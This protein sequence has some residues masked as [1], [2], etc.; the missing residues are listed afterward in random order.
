MRALASADCNC[1]FDIC[2]TNFEPQ[3]W[4]YN[5]M[6]NT[7]TLHN[8]NT[9]GTVLDTVT[10][11]TGL[12]GLGIGKTGGTG[13][14]GSTTGQAIGIATQ[15]VQ[16]L[17]VPT[18]VRNSVTQSTINPVLI[19]LQNP[20]LG[21]WQ[22]GKPKPR[23]AFSLPTL[24]SEVTSPNDK[25]LFE[26]P[27]DATKKHYIPQ[28][29]IATRGTGGGMVKWVSFAPTAQGFVLSVHLSDT[30]SASLSAN[31]TAVKPNSIR[32]MLTANLQGRAVSWDF[33]TANVEQDT[34]V[35][36]LTVS[37][38]GN[39]NSIYHAMID[40][41]A[42]AQ[43]IIRNSID[44]AVMVPPSGPPS[45]PP[46]PVTYRESITAIDSS[47]PFTFDPDLDKNVFAQLTGVS[48]G[49]ASLNIQQVT[50]NGRPYPYYQDPNQPGQVYY[51]PDTF[52]ISRAAIAPHTPNITIGTNGSDPNTLTFTVSFLGVPVWDPNRLTAA[53]A[54][55]QNLFFLDTPPAFALLEATNTS[56]ALTL[57]PSDGS[58][59]PGLA[60]Q[61]GANI[62]IGAGIKCSVTLTLPQFQQVYA[63]LFDRISQ[64][65]SGVVT[66]TVGSDVRKIPFT[67]SAADFAGDIFDTNSSFDPTKNQFVVT[68]QNSIESPIH[69]DTLPAV[70]MKGDQQVPNTV[71]QIAPTLPIDLVPVSAASVSS[72]ASSPASGQSGSS[73]PAPVSG[74]TVTVQLAQGT[75][76]DQNSSVLF[77]YS[78]THVMP[79]PD[80]IW[81]AIMQNQVVG[82]V[83]R[84]VK[85][86]VFSSIFNQPAP[87]TASGSSPSSA[88]SGAGSSGASG[89]SSSS[90]PSSGA[91]T[92]SASGPDTGSS[93][94]G[95][96]SGDGGGTSSSSS[97]ASSSPTPPPTIMAVQV[98]FEDGQTASFDPSTPATSGIMTQTVSLSVPVKMYVLQSG[99]ASIYKYRIVLV[100][101]AGTQTGDW[102]TSNQDSF[103]VQVNG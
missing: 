22:F 3:E 57:P 6:P 98:V 78:H 14:T 86:M 7:F 99:D 82:P 74:V 65:L 38:L 91:D 75:T 33:N 72:S 23:S 71:Q 4:V 36:T 81:E 13:G 58:S 17:L 80:A 11:L 21:G 84:T 77:D 31:N 2:F 16:G 25:T 83:K 15:T 92:S 50:W 61:T 59:S 10:G 53:A 89:S 87:A 26:E 28:Y 12:T 66:V 54:T 37:D 63:A 47:I 93:T 64:L 39:R 40:A 52:K 95:A 49:P 5:E 20:V 45:D 19:Y 60:P 76:V 18:S 56:L 94:D 68:L 34:L 97:P 101:S 29:A 96:G 62:D 67:S 43:L 27:Q 8:V 100:T 1:R 46:P 90:A 24:I 79:D 73:S 44:L 9:T 88:S 55:L 85:M 69:V 30:T 41:A 103:Y 42:Q 51:L 70:L 102:I 32:Y 48:G 35:L